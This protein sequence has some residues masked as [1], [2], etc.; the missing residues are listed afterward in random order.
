MYYKRRQTWHFLM[1]IAVVRSLGFSICTLSNLLQRI[2]FMNE[3]PG[4]QTDISNCRW[5][6]WTIWLL[7]GSKYSPFVWPS[8]C[9]FCRLFLHSILH[10]L[11]AIHISWNTLGVRKKRK[12]RVSLLWRHKNGK[13]K[14]RKIGWFMCY[15]SAHWWNPFLAN[16]VLNLIIK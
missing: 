6:Y 16:P 15:N 13:N 7:I 3:T 1:T 5:Y 10:P 2:Y 12:K 8:Y 4:E 14:R 11:I 9:A